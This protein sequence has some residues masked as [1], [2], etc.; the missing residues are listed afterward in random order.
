MADNHKTSS[1]AIENPKAPPPSWQAGELAG[2]GCY[3]QFSDWYHGCRCCSPA[4][5]CA[6]RND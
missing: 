6:Q 2:G 3:G 4:S 5:Q 1:E